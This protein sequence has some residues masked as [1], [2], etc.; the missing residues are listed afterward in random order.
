MKLTLPKVEPCS[1]RGRVLVGLGVQRPRDRG[2]AAEEHADVR[3]G[4]LLSQGREHTVPVRST[5]MRW[6]PEGCDCVLVSPDILNL[7]RDEKGSRVGI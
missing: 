3:I 2:W 1:A 5:E 6:G 7:T 4:M